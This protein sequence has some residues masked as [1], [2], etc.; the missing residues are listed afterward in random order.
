MDFHVIIL[1]VSKIVENCVDRFLISLCFTRMLT[2]ANRSRVS[3]RVTENF[4]QGR[5]RC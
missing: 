2:T 1:T 4:G 5:K 3:I